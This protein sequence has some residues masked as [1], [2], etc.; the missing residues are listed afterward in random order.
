MHAGLHKN[1]SGMRDKHHRTP[2][3]SLLTPHTSHL[4]SHASFLIPHTSH[5][6]SHSLNHTPRTSCLRPPNLPP[7]TSDVAPHTAQP[8]SHTSRLTPLISHIRPHSSLV[9]QEIFIA[10]GGMVSMLPDSGMLQERLFVWAI[11]KHELTNLMFLILHSY[12]LCAFYCRAMP[13]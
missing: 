13:C 5:L 9:R 1:G 12:T 7:E 3:T 4:T 6:T 10:Q 11:A 8:T 2:H